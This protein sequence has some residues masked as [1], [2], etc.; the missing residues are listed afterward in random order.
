M[1]FTAAYSHE[2]QASRQ[3]SDL[4]SDLGFRAAKVAVNRCGREGFHG[5]SHYIDTGVHVQVPSFVEPSR[6]DEF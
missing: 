5:K 4:R 2:P 6:A 1:P 3:Y